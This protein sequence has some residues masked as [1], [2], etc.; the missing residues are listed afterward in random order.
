MKA[1]RDRARSP[2]TPLPDHRSLSSRTQP[3]SSRW[4]A[5]VLWQQLLVIIPQDD[6]PVHPA[7]YRLPC[8]AVPPS[9]WM[10]ERVPSVASAQH[11]SLLIFPLHLLLASHLGSIQRTPRLGYSQL[12]AAL[13]L[14]VMRRC[15]LEQSVRRIPVR[16]AKRM[17]GRRTIGG[18]NAYIR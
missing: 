18:T 5:R 17:I 7:D 15:G 2:S 11:M 14:L 16:Y 13:A 9:S 3:P 6:G 1:R 4:H 12:S 10:G 8:C